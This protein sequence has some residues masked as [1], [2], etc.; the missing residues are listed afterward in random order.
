YYWI[1]NCAI[2]TPFYDI[3]YDDGPASSYRV[4]DSR[5]TL[6]LPSGPSYS[7]F[8]LVPLLNLVARKKCLFVGGPGRGKTASAVIMG[9][10]SGYGLE[11][12]RRAI[13]HGQPQMTVADLFGS[14]VPSDIM[15]SESLRDIRIAWKSWL[16]MRIKIIDEYNRIPTRTQS[17]LLTVMAD[18]YAEMMDQVYDCPEAAWYL[19]ANDDAGGGTY[20]V[21]EA[22]R[23]RIDVV[24]RALHFNTRFLGQLLSRIEAGIKPEEAVPAEIVFT[25]EELELARREVLAVGLPPGVLR[26]IEHFASQFEFFEPAGSQFEYRTKDAVKVSGGDFARLSASET[27]KDKAADFGQQTRNGLSVR[28]LM[29]SLVF[30]KAIAF[31]RGSPTASLDDARAILPFVFHDKLS[32]NPD[33]AFFEQEGNGVFRIDRVGWLRAL[34][35]RSCAEF[36][37][38]GM[39]GADEVGDALATFARGLEGVP[40]DVA[41]AELA[42]AEKLI[43]AIAS[44]RKLTGPLYDDLLSLKYLHQR[45][46]AYIRWLK[47]RG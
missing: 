20:E 14:P 13:Q 3:E 18:D 40:L 27:G 32:Q 30:V 15:K 25:P 16:G 11:D 29:T 31:F 39:D 4:G 35:D 37:R 17:A 10:L 33:A 26:R 43:A 44:E 12:V 46:S 24:V 8:V 38:L 22:L 23:D 5:A 21:I 7:S 45:W 1:T 47:W 9:V 36:D 34:F 19:T 42:R 28:A 6:T 41:E 2:I